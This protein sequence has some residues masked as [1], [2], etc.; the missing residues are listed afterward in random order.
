MRER[1]EEVGA[2]RAA[3]CI[4]LGVQVVLQ[5]DAFL[6]AAPDAEDVDAPANPEVGFA[7]GGIEEVGQRTGLEGQGKAVDD[8][9]RVAA[10]CV[11]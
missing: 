5:F 1:A 3:S 4:E 2:R 6:Q 9:G 8:L 7:F 10:Q 11:A